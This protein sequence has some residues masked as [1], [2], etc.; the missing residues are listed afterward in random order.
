MSVKTVYCVQPFWRSGKRLVRAEM[1]QFKQEDEA[2]R[3][4]E[5]FYK[6]HAGVMV[7]SMEGDPEYEDS[8]GQLKVVAT[9]GEV[10][11]MDA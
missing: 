2:R 9:F 10:P 6:N 5:R 8:W 4:G 3:A 7:Y 1:R 11:P